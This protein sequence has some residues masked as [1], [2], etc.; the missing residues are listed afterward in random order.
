MRV[1]SLGDV[2]VARDEVS[3]PLAVG[4]FAGDGGAADA[5]V[6]AAGEEQECQQAVS[7]LIDGFERVFASFGS[8]LRAEEPAFR[9]QDCDEDAVVF[10]DLA[11]QLGDAEVVVLGHGIE[12]L[13][14]VECNDGSVAAS[15]VEDCLLGGWIAGH[16]G[17]VVVGWSVL[18]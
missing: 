2:E 1:E 18:L 15:F 6:G 17:L 11:E 5:Y 10:G 12:L 13:L 7:G 14:K 3:Q 9:G 8:D 16:D 4:V